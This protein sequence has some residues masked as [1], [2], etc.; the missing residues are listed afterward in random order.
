MTSVA[1]RKRTKRAAR[2]LSPARPKPALVI[3]NTARPIVRES[4][5]EWLVARK[6]ITVAHQRAGLRWG[7][8]FRLILV[9]GLE[10]LRSCLNDSPRGSGGGVPGMSFAAAETEAKD[11]RRRAEAALHWQD[12][13]IGA[14][15]AVCGRQLTPWERVREVGGKQ[16]DVEELQT[17][18][19]LAL[20]IL[21]KHYRL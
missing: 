19:R 5:L 8:D 4:G 6:R 17:T 9:D 14:L 13:M 12:D 20:D 1:E 7:A 16:K 2:Q 11:S 15:D 3:D 18:L 21:S 10:P